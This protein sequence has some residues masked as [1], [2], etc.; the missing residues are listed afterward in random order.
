VLID[1]TTQRPLKVD[2]VAFG[3]RNLHVTVPDGNLQ[4]DVLSD[5][6]AEGEIP[7]AQAGVG[8]LNYGATDFRTGAVSVRRAP[9][10]P[11]YYWV[12]AEPI[13]GDFQQYTGWYRRLEY[14]FL[15]EGA[16]FLNE[17]YSAPVDYKKVDAEKKVIFEYVSI[18]DPGDVWLRFEDVL[19]N[20]KVVDLELPDCPSVSVVC[21][22]EKEIFLV[23]ELTDVDPPCD[24]PGECVYF[25]IP[26]VPFKIEAGLLGE[27]PYAGLEG[28]LDTMWGHG[29]VHEIPIGQYRRLTYAVHSGI[30][31]AGAFDE[32]LAV[33]WQP[34]WAGGGFPVNWFSSVVDPTT[35]GS[36]L[37]YSLPSAVNEVTRILTYDF[38]SNAEDGNGNNLNIPPT[39]LSLTTTAFKVLHESGDDAGFV[40]AFHA[41]ADSDHPLWDAGDSLNRFLPP[42]STLKRNGYGPARVPLTISPAGS[43]DPGESAVAGLRGTVPSRI[44]S[45]YCASMHGDN[46]DR[47]CASKPKGDLPTTEEFFSLDNLILYFADRYGLPPDVIKAIAVKESGQVTRT[48]AGVGTNRYKY[49]PYTFDFRYFAGGGWDPQGG[50]RCD[51][52]TPNYDYDAHRIEVVPFC[53]YAF[54]GRM[55]QSDGIRAA[56]VTPSLASPYVIDLRDV[57]FPNHVRGLEQL[58]LFDDVPQN[59]PNCITKTTGQTDPPDCTPDPADFGVVVSG[60]EQVARYEHGKPNPKPHAYVEYPGVDPPAAGQYSVEYGLDTARVTL[61]SAPTATTQILANVQLQR[62]LDY[63]AGGPGW[64]NM[65]LNNPVADIGLFLDSLS[66][67]P[68]CKTNPMTT[69]SHDQPT[70]DSISEWFRQSRVGCGG[71]NFI[72]DG[73][74]A[75]PNLMVNGSDFT[76]YDPQFTVNAQYLLA[77]TFGLMQYGILNHNYETISGKFLRME[78]DFGADGFHLFD[79]VLNPAVS[80][81]IGSAFLYWKLYRSNDL[82][83]VCPSNCSI[84]EL[85]GVVHEAVG[86]YNGGG[87]NYSDLVFAPIYLFSYDSTI[88]GIAQNGP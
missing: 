71:F 67:N 85:R 21:R 24:P 29:A 70:S 5:G 52:P 82:S 1:P 26:P 63:E 30:S 36:T 61:G 23:P 83:S 51:N 27:D 54:S 69:N 64:Q 18:D 12:I 46:A 86:D 44:Q 73:T 48:S 41:A 81:Q 10:R 45:E 13:Q 7:D 2:D 65:V 15:V 22:V 58:K 49:E 37:N 33:E 72:R 59:S 38:D 19:G 60:Y 57:G 16:A 40:M 79:Q 76:L 47:M 50:R 77:G 87:T 75:H 20:V 25:E 17:D 42:D 62:Q 56:T 66:E 68:N 31:P 80:V 55:R 35:D 43:S 3:Y 32:P 9:K 88:W 78:M 14:L 53:Q 4:V 39:T 74:A 6:E 28:V 84:E 34:S 8:Y 11:G